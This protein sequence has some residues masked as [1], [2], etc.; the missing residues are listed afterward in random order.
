MDFYIEEIETNLD[1][2]NIYEIWKGEKNT[3]FLDSSKEESKY[4][5]YSFIGINNF[6]KFTSKKTNTFVNDVLVSENP[7]ETLDSLLKKYKLNIES[8]I[9]FVSGAIG[10]ISYDTMRIL[11]NFEDKSEKDYDIWDM[12]FLFYDNLIIKELSSGKVYITG[13]GIKESSKVSVNKIKIAILEFNKNFIKKS[14]V[15]NRKKNKF[16]SNFTREEYIKTVN[17]VKS[18][19]EDGDTYIMNLTQRFKCENKEESYNLYS[20]LREINPAPFSC[21]LNL[22]NVQVISSSPER[23]LNIR[24]SI[25]ETRPIKG[26]VP[27]GC[28]AKED[29]INKNILLNSEKDKAELLMVVDLERNDLSKVCKTNS[30]KVTELFKLEEYATVFHLVAT[31]QGELEEAISNVDCIKAAF[32]GGSITGTPKIRTIE[33]IEELEK[34]KRG[35]YTGIIGYFDFRGNCDFNIVIRTIVKQNN[36]A[37]FNVGGGITI[38]SDAEAEYDETLDKAQAL[39]RVL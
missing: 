10:Y 19:I 33:I 22:D 6:L 17:K 8:K 23:F 25:V 36:M 11:E 1:L 31:I 35:L 13:L 38:E 39:M 7:F 21:Y 24:N 2:H 27:R 9:P 5:N 3:I 14:I 15:F 37:Y 34:L 16:E 20:K 29:I 28:N 4:S 32:P 18:Y 30:V 12:Y 26:T